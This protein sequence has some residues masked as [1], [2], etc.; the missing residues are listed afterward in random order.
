ML[1]F[2]NYAPQSE[3]LQGLDVP[4]PVLPNVEE[5]LGTAELQ[6]VPE[7]PA[8]EAL[9]RFSKFHLGSLNTCLKGRA[10]EAIELADEPSIGCIVPF[11]TAV[12]APP[13]TR[14][15]A[16]LAPRRDGHLYR[17]DGSMSTIRA[18]TSTPTTARRWWPVS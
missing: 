6:E 1:R 16:P 11:A 13:L 10:K 17:R 2:R 5:E 12:G 9:E 8:Q 7:L 15:T 3:A 18:M 4:K 14:N